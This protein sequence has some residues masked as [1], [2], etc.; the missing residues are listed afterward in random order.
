MYGKLLVGIDIGSS[1]IKLVAAERRDTEE[2][3]FLGEKSIEAKGIE[4]GIIK[5]HYDASNAITNLIVESQKLIGRQI[6]DIYITVP[7][8]ICQLI[9][10]KGE[11]EVNDGEGIIGKRDIQRA[12]EAAC[13]IVTPHD[14]KFIQLIENKYN[15][16]EKMSTKNPIRMKGRSLVLEGRAV[17]ISAKCY[18]DYLNIFKELDIEVNGL[19]IACEAAAELLIDDLDKNRG[20]ILVDC[21]KNKIDI[22]TFYEGILQEVMQVAVGGEIITKDISYCFK[23]NGVQAEELK[24]FSNTGSSDLHT[25][26]PIDYNLLREVIDARLLEMGEMIEKELKNRK[27]NT[28]IS[29]IIIYGQGISLFNNISNRF[30]SISDRNISFVGSELYDHID[31]K[32]MNARGLV[33]LV[34]NEL[35]WDYEKENVSANVIEENVIKNKTEKSKFIKKHGIVSKMKSILEDLF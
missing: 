2:L 11:V 3:K 24:S 12:R 34:Y 21:G 26:S 5:N 31:S 22:A 19:R 16:D 15:I 13:R 33:N 35:K 7:S 9:H 8:G 23:I 18:K 30:S 17:L 27:N 4:K 28:D 32:Y 20:A 10:T 14:Y 25:T 1:E 29:N 6:T